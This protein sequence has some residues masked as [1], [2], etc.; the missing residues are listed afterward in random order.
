[1]ARIRILSAGNRMPDWVDAGFDEYARRLPRDFA[2]ELREFPLS[3]LRAGGATARAVEEEGR[4]LLDAVMPD[5]L[6]VAL[7]LS[8]Q[9]W[10]TEELAARL[11]GWRDAARRVNFLIG[12]PDGLSEA[13]RRRADQQ[14]SLSRLTLPHALVRILL[15]EQLYRAFS[16][17]S[18]HPYHR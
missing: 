3:K 18:A 11:R 14:W 5:D 9:S 17:V 8:G 10:S 1:M 4:T 15:I 16:I 13:C 6:V 7:E 12:G 2:V